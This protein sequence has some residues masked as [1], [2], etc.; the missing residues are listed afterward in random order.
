VAKV[1]FWAKE[2]G[3]T[4]ISHDLVFGLPFQTLENVIDTIEKTNS[5]SPDRVAF[6]SYAHVPWI[7]GNGQRG[8]KDEDVPKDDAKRLLYEEGKKL[9]AQNKTPVSLAVVV[10]NVETAIG[11]F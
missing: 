4:S 2:I 1:T 10:I 5:L 3:Y 9:L 6:Y 7:K 11:E 8:F